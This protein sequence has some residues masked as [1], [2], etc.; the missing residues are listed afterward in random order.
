MYNPSPI[1][2]NRQSVKVEYFISTRTRTSDSNSP[3]LP[4]HTSWNHNKLSIVS[5]N[6]GFCAHCLSM[7]TL[8]STFWCA[9]F[10]FFLRKM[11]SL[12]LPMH[13]FFL[14]LN[15]Q[16]KLYHDSSNAHPMFVE[17][18][19][20]TVTLDNTL[21]PWAVRWAM[22]SLLSFLQLHFPVIKLFLCTGSSLSFSFSFFS[23]ICCL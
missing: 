19:Q 1:Q 21:W 13:T 18:R 3:Y 10:F 5:N 8:S 6:I 20:H 23:S 7:L 14:L 11:S 16:L 22:I 4:H 17:L 2:N 15:P 9:H 12:R